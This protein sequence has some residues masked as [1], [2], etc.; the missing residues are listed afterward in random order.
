M[1]T[2]NRLPHPEDG[3]DAFQALADALGAQN[4]FEFIRMV[5]THTGGEK[6]DIGA[7]ALTLTAQIQVAREMEEAN[8]DFETARQRVAAK[9]GYKDAGARSNFYKI[10]EGKRRQDRRYANPGRKA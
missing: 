6:R 4:V 8:V 3:M 1:G 2:I 7:E 10:L 5:R 9:L